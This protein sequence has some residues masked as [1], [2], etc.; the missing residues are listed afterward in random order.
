LNPSGVIRVKITITSYAFLTGVV[1][2]YRIKDLS[3]KWFVICNNQAYGYAKLDEMYLWG[4]AK[5][6]EALNMQIGERIELAFNTWN[7]NLNLRRL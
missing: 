2:A 6:F 1:S 4:L 7:R 5:A 3:G